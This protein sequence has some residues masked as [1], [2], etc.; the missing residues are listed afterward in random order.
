MAKRSAKTNPPAEK[1]K[2]IQI[3]E[4]KRTRRFIRIHYRKGDEDFKI[5]SNENPL[6]ELA[7]SLNALRPVLCR[8][9]QVDSAWGDDVNITGIAFGEM[10]DAQTV[11]I[12]AQKPLTVCGKVM[13][14]VSPPALL[15]TPKTEGTVTPPLDAEDVKLIEEA[16]EQIREYTIGKRAQGTLGLDEDEE[17]VDEGSYSVDE[18]LLTDSPTVTEVVA[19]EKAKKKRS[20]K[21]AEVAVH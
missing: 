9:V 6:P 5:R 17:D 18:P 3:L 13:K 19:E 12:H 21:K 1:P 7:L 14:V 15:E 4:A 20:R 8:I 10:R 2:L 16:R 11:I